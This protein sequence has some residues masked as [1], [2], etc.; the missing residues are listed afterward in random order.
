MCDWSENQ[1]GHLTSPILDPQ[2]TDGATT[3]TPA[4]QKAAGVS[5]FPISCAVLPAPTFA[6]AILNMLIKASKGNLQANLQAKSISF[7]S[8]R[9]L[10]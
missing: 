2:A 6:S 5:S 4:V 3:E 9:L 7:K 8:D 1:S 10:G